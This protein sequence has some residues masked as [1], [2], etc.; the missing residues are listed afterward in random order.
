[1]GEALTSL[2]AQAP[3]TDIVPVNETPTKSRSSVRKGEVLFPQKLL[4][5]GFVFA[6]SL[7][8]VCLLAGAWYLYSFLV[9]TSTGI[10]SLIGSAADKSI[11][12]STVEIAINA[13]LVMARLAFL[14]CGTFIGMSFGFLGFALFLLGIKGE[15]G[16]DAGSESYRIKLARM[17]PGI[18]VI[19]CATILIVI[20]V[21]R[22]TPF[23]YEVVGNSNSVPSLPNPGNDLKP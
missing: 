3:R 8:G 21:T 15:M 10:S 20:C 11:T 16:L 22:Q 14:S 18:F 13:R 2:P 23:S 19:L 1:M 7:A 4:N 17:S 5:I 6:L 12:E 9:A